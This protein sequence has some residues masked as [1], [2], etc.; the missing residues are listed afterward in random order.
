RRGGQY[1][2]VIDGDL[3][4]L[5]RN[6]TQKP[7]I[8]TPEERRQFHAMLTYIGQQRGHKP[9]AAA[10]RYKEKFGAWPIDR[11]IEPIPPSAEVLAWDRHCRIRYAKSQ[12]KAQAA[13][14]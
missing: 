9:G 7:P 2:D 14:A 3:A 6:G 5:E 1:Q 10:H 8:Y 4:H 13:Y 12:Q 11:Q